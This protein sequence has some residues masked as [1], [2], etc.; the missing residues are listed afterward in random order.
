MEY[1]QRVQLL[2]LFKQVKLGSYSAEKDTDTGYFDVVGAD[3][4]Y[5]PSMMRCWLCDVL[6]TDPGK[7]GRLLETFP[8]KGHSVR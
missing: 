4:R 3:R 2:A 7:H 8:K 1:A 5:L 6:L